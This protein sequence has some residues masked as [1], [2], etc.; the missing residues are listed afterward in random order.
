MRLVLLPPVLFSVAALA[1]AEGA[2][3]KRRG[4]DL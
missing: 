1:C 4:E 2:C 3:A